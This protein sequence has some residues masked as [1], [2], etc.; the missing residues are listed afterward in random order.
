M[1]RL[2]PRTIPFSIDWLPDGRLLLVDGPQRL[3][4]RQEPDGTLRTAADLTGFGAAP[5]NELVVDAAGNAYVNGGPG[6]VVRVGSDGLAEPCSSRRRM[7]R[8]G[9]GD[10][11]RARPERTPARRRRP[12]RAS[13][14]SPLTAA[15]ISAAGPA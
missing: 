12:A 10:D 2:H 1:A 8:N 5:F 14:R 13:R 15:P 6:S 4:L 9:G 3:L 7:A 11:R